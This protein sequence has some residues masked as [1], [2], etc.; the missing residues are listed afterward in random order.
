MQFH[1]MS[2]FALA[3][4][5]RQR[6]FTAV[7]VLEH[8][9][10]RIERY[11]PDLNAIVVLRADDARRQAE[12]ADAAVERVDKGDG[13]V[14]GDALGPLHGVPMTIKET[15]EIKGW[16][17]TAG[18]A[19]FKDYISP[20]TAPA[21]ERLQAA[22][23]I[24]L[25]KTNVPE[26]AGD[27]QTFNSI[28]GTTANPWDTRLTPGGSSGG[29]AAALAAGLVPMELGSDIGGSIRTPAAF[30][31]VYGLK[32]TYGVIPTRGHIPG[33]PGSRG[34]RDIG[35]AGPMGRHLDDLERALDLLAG[36]DEAEAPA[37]RID[38]PQ[39][40]TETL[41]GL[42]VAA[43]LDD[44]FCPV[45]ASVEKGLRI[46]VDLLRER[47]A[48]IDEAARPD[49]L[50][51]EQNHRLYYSLLAA[52]MGAGLNTNTLE[53]LAAVAR[54]SENDDY[55]TRFARGASLTHTDWM[56]QDEERAQLQHRWVQFFER[57]DVMICP[58]V[59]TP[60]FP[61]DQDAPAMERVLTINGQPQVYMDVT[62]WAGI[63]AIAGLPA[64][65]LPVGFSDEG[66]P[67]AVQLIG[68]AYS[69]RNLIQI[70]RLMSHHLHPEGLTFPPL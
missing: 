30:C 37:W 32:A 66:L 55:R 9:L 50:T 4:G 39:A 19:K 43:W 27:L 15:F 18:Y 63:A 54:D 6:Q 34:K 59:N 46:A 35:V 3:Q 45:D 16:P 64:L 67:L 65:S 17:T 13:S 1:E 21:V 60:P 69:E 24:V 28:Y 31:G 11:N 33:P 26:L 5:I 53:K 20:R 70:A 29:A 56:R 23:A 12:A 47:G 49:D 36:P 7:E 57:F 68:P 40:Q 10:D 38:L 2:A 14:G 41:A 22:G 52:T 62:V 8:F 51:L 42:K 44:A 48:T 61:H 58:V 25:G